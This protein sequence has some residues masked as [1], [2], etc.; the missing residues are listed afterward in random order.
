MLT[1]QIGNGGSPAIAPPAFNPPD[2][3][4]P[5]D[6]AFTGPS[7]DART[8]W[9]RDRGDVAPKPFDTLQQLGVA[10]EAMKG[11]PEASKAKIAEVF[12][13]IL[14]ALI[15]SSKP[16]LGPGGPG[17]GVGPGVPNF[18]SPTS[19]SG[20]AIPP[21][22]GGAP[23]TPE[24]VLREGLFAGGSKGPAPTLFAPELLVG[25][26]ETEAIQLGRDKG[27]DVR[28]I[29]REG[30]EAMRTMEYRPDR[31][32]LDVVGGTVTGVKRG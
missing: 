13:L 27:I 14:M 10:V 7:F 29:S 25:K 2:R 15:E 32:N 4:A 23:K 12:R 16:Q 5:K 11:L 26:S 1:P 24:F 22:A 17:G 31:L 3:T 19:P 21:D 8:S 30:V 6:V 18:G 28:T 9:P 20:P